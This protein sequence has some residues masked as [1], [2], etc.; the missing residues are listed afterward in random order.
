[1]SVVT[2]GSSPT[3]FHHQYYQGS[4]A[5]QGAINN[6]FQQEQLSSN[7]ASCD[8]NDIQ[9]EN[10]KHLVQVDE[11]FYSPQQRDFLAN[12]ASP[13]DK[14]NYK[15]KNLSLNDDYKMKEVGR[16]VLSHRDMAKSEVNSSSQP[17]VT[18][19]SS[20]YAQSLLAKSEHNSN[21]AQSLLA[22]SEHNSQASNNFLMANMKKEL[23]E[24]CIPME[25]ELEYGRIG[26]E[27]AKCERSQNGNDDEDNLNN[28]CFTNNHSNKM[29][30]KA[31]ILNDSDNYS[32]SN[33]RLNNGVENSIHP[34]GWRGSSISDLR[35]RAYE[36]TVTMA[37]YK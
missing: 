5:Y 4:P 22:K 8:D 31:S 19:T 35:R 14:Y 26:D 28:I 37:A 24:H 3:F 33:L 11:G 6:N 34:Y 21:Y 13:Y 32:R 15:M 9:E 18:Q 1:M 29:T 36:H 16:G 23:A 25:K 17:S 20:N 27:K 10:P 7:V 30:D 12:T 2:D